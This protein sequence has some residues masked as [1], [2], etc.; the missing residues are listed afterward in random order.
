MNRFGK[1]LFLRFL[2]T[3][4]LLAVVGRQDSPAQSDVKIEGKVLDGSDR[5]ALFG[6]NVT[7]PGT[8]G[9]SV[10]DRNGLVV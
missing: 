6:V 9:G 5:H 10:T 4:L 7:V 3:F 8:A 1:K 2:L